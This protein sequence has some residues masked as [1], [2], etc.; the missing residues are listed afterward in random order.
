MHALLIIDVQNDFA[1]PE[2]SLFVPGAPRVMGFINEQIA[3][4]AE[5][6]AVIVY[7][8]DWHPESTP[9]FVAARVSSTLVRVQL[10]PVPTMTWARWLRDAGLRRAVS[11]LRPFE[12]AAF[13]ELLLGCQ[14]KHIFYMVPAN[15]TVTLSSIE[16]V[17]R[18]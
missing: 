1:H 10:V 8:Q 13:A 4:A 7:T 12:R 16:I 11:S 2:G 18:S 6:G 5:A 14:K 3:T 17:I 15:S 9:H